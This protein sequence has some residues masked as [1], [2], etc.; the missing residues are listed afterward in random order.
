MNIKQLIYQEIANIEEDKL[1]EL[2][3]MI[4]NFS[5]SS[6]IKNDSLF[7]KLK[8][9]KIEGPVDFATNVNLYLDGEKGIDAD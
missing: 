3:E 9:V 7:T 4:R 8:K 5:Q 2:Y 6:S 1:T